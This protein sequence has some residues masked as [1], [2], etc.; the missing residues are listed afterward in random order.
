MFQRCHLQNNKYG[1]FWRKTLF[2][3]MLPVVN[4]IFWNLYNLLCCN[5]LNVFYIFKSPSFV[6]VFWACGKA[7]SHTKPCLESM[8]ASQVGHICFIKKLQIN[9]YAWVGTLLWWIF[10]IPSYGLLHKTVSQRQLRTVGN[11]TWLFAHGEHIH[12]ELHPGGQRKLTTW[13]W[14]IVSWLPCFV[15]PWRLLCFL[16]RWPCLCFRVIIKDVRHLW[17]QHV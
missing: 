14:H 11:Q 10:W 7:K 16:L 15:W 13:P 9:C 6:V 8:E 3:L 2:P 12:D 1:P 17:S 4:D 5:S